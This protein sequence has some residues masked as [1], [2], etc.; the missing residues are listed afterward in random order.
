MFVCLVFVQ[1]LWF[2][3]TSVLGGNKLSLG[4]S[5]CVHDVLR[6][7]GILAKEYP[8]LMTSVPG[9]SSRSQTRI[10]RLT[11][12]NESPDLR[13]AVLTICPASL[14]CPHTGFFFFFLLRVDLIRKFFL[15]SAPE[16]PSGRISR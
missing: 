7:T 9:I 15:K 11:R 6:C 10:K 8:C 12:M 1:V 4:E 14:I 16:K 13:A 3:P 5:V 2:P